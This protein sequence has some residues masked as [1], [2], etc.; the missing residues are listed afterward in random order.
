[1][2]Y[3]GANDGMLH[4]FNGLTG[5][6]ALAFIPSAV[7]PNLHELTKP[8][9]SHRFFVDGTPTVGDAFYSSAWHTMLVAGLN[10][11]GRSIYALDVTYP[12]N[13]S[14]ANAASIFKWEYTNS[15]LGYTYSRPAIVRMANGVWAAVFGSGYHTSSSVVGSTG[16]AYLYIVNISTGVLIR[17]ID[18]TVGTVADPNGLGTPALVDLDGDSIVDYAYA[19]DLQGNLWKFN[20]TSTNSASWDVAYIS[21]TTR[22]PLFVAT[23]AGGVRQPITSRPEVGVGP[24]GMGMIVLFG[25][26]K[27]M[28]LSDKSPTQTQSFYGLVDNNLLD[29]DRPHQWPL[30]HDAAVDP[31]RGSGHFHHGARWARCRHA[32][33]RHLHDSGPGHHQE[34]GGRSDRAR[35]VSGSA[36]TECA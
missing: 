21:G 22:N 9:Y 26:G 12:E 7:F 25:T 36:V 33:G 29:G 11:G 18:T 8:S 15:D 4:A 6:E 13:F 19:G 16:R 10:R 34:S 31:L 20:L 23:N 28:E 1:M 32:S 17:K 5:V 3:T 30:R 2:V 24:K 35:L 14:E 27:F